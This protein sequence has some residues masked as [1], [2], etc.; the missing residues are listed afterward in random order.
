MP[1]LQIQGRVRFDNVTYRYAPGDAPALDQIDLDIGPGQLVAVVGPP[2]SGKSTLAKL[3]L[4]LDR[5]EQGRILVDDMDTRL[6]SPTTLRQQ[7]GVVPQDVQL[8]TGSIADNISIG[9][10]DQSFERVVAAAKFV[11]AHDFIQRLPRGY[12]TGLGERGGG[13]SAGQRQLVTIARALIRNPRV[14]ILDEATSALDAA[15]EDELLLNL[16]RASRGRT[17]I[18]VTHRHA[19]LRLADRVLSLA[20]GQIVRD[21]SPGQTAASTGT[22]V[23]AG[24][25]SIRP[26]LRP[27]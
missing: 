11:G 18:M 9:A 13:L 17:I 1:A 22:P 4:G 7:I 26:H 21:G 8:F 20:H 15:T 10:A 5:P 16:K 25:D 23:R 24:G 27:V 2:G 14:L 6:W 12:E 19:G 3:L